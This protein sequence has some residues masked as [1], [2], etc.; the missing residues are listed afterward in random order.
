MEGAWVV[1]TG[2]EPEPYSVI[3]VKKQNGSKQKVRVKEPKPFHQ[4]YVS[5]VEERLS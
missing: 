5:L 3:E 2:F 4:G 1:Y